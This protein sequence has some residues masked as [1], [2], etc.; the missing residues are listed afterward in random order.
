MEEI[1]TMYISKVKPWKSSEWVAPDLENER[2]VD[3]QLYKS[4]EQP[5]VQQQELV[6]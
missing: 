2:L 4:A 1:D 5:G 3:A 6:E